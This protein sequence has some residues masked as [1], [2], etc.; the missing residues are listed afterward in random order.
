MHSY[1]VRHS[2]NNDTTHTGTLQ[3]RYSHSFNS[4]SKI[5]HFLIHACSY[6]HIHMATHDVTDQSTLIYWCIFIGLFI[7]D[8][9]MYLYKCYTCDPT[10]VISCCYEWLFWIYRDNLEALTHGSM[11][12]VYCLANEQAHESIMSYI[13]FYMGTNLT[14]SVHPTNPWHTFVCPQTHPSS[15]PIHK[16]CSNFNM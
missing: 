2:P 9:A 3:H 15:H 5:I 13:P 14:N 4:C 8:W 12:S 10:G 1:H 7:Q 6:I 11:L 16:H